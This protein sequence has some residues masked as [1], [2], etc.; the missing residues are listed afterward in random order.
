MIE[1]ATIEVSTNKLV[2]WISFDHNLVIYLA[3]S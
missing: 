2:F 3:E 1:N